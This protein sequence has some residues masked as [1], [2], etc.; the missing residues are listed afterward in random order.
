ML[1]AWNYRA[2]WLADRRRACRGN[3][4]VRRL[5]VA[6]DGVRWLTGR[7]GCSPGVAVAVADSTR[8][9]RS[10]KLSPVGGP[11]GTA[12]RVGGP[13]PADRPACWRPRGVSGDSVWHSGDCGAGGAG[14]GRRVRPEAG[15]LRLGRRRGSAGVAARCR[16]GGARQ[17]SGACRVR[18]WRGPGGA[19][20]VEHG[21]RWRH[22]I[23]VDPLCM[24]GGLSRAWCAGLVSSSTLAALRAPGGLG[25]MC[26]GVRSC[27]RA[28]PQRDRI[29]DWGRL[30]RDRLRDRRR[31]RWDRIAD[32]SRLLRIGLPIAARGRPAWVRRGP[33]RGSVGRV[34]CAARM[35]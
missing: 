24:V 35:R 19:A 7:S 10:C 6:G 34:L 23:V 8:S 3:N 30:A 18:Q 5:R 13:Q 28:G 29:G 4:H 33:R 11:G 9:R 31:L 25:F 21:C 14:F 32:R 22:R 16:A 17:V 27:E 15:Q 20:R 12:C 26:G 1:K 2:A